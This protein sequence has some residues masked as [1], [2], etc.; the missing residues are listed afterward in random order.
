MTNKTV[1]HVH[2]MVDHMILKLMN[3]TSLSLGKKKHTITKRNL[4]NVLR[5]LSMA[6]IHLRSSQHTDILPRRLG[7]HVLKQM[8]QKVRLA[9]DAQPV[10]REIYVSFVERVLDVLKGESFTG[11][12]KPD[13]VAR[14]MK[15]SYLKQFI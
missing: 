10:I 14:V 13:D 15:Q 5:V 7:H 1:H 11:R 8:D 4:D 6:G 2:A 3:V 12:I 9:K